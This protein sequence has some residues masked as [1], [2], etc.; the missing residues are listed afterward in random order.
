MTNRIYKIVPVLHHG[1][2]IQEIGGLAWDGLVKQLYPNDELPASKKDTNLEERKDVEI[3]MELLDEYKNLF[4]D[5]YTIYLHIY[6][7]SWLIPYLIPTDFDG[8]SLT[9]KIDVDRV[10]ADSQK[11]FGGQLNHEGIHYSRKN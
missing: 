9:V 1:A 5:S 8:E 11:V 3:P 6:C 4:N 7:H 2:Y 10:I